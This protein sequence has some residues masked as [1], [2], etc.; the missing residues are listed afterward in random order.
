MRS[1]TK[2]FEKRALRKG[3]YSLIDKE[4]TFY[5]MTDYNSI[6]YYNDDLKQCKEIAEK[7]NFKTC[8]VMDVALNSD[9]EYMVKFNDG[10]IVK[11][12]DSNLFRIIHRQTGEELKEHSGVIDFD[13]YGLLRAN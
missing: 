4:F 11:V 6:C 8:L 3:K 5:D 10:K 2:E 13:T 1:Y 9:S 12:Y 7:Y